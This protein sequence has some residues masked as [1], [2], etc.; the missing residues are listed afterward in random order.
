MKRSRATAVVLA[1]TCTAGAA[2]LAPSGPTYDL[3]W[4][5]IDGGAGTSTGGAF[6]LIGTIGQPDA[7]VMSGG[8]FVLAGGF[9]P[10]NI[11]CPWDCD[12]TNDGL[13]GVDDF[14]EV[15]AQWTMIGTSCDFGLGSAGVGVD[16]FLKVFEKWGLCP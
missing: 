8:G 5:T 7:A 2:A 10:G 9:V 6:E 12:G 13:V 11:T 4:N 14:L 16:E 15:F 3:S 1:V